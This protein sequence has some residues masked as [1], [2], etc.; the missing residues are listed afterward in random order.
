MLVERHDYTLKGWQSANTKKY[1]LIKK[2]ADADR[3]NI[4]LVHISETC[5]DLYIKNIEIINVLPVDGHFIDK[6]CSPGGEFAI[7]LS[8]ISFDGNEEVKE[9]KAALCHYV[10]KDEKDEDLLP[11]G[12][13]KV[14]PAIGPFFYLG[15]HDPDANETA[16]VILKSE[17][18]AK[19]LCLRFIQW[20]KNLESYFVSTDQEFIRF[21]EIGA[22]P[23]FFSYI[24]EEMDKIAANQKDGRLIVIYSGNS[25]KMQVKITPLRI[26]YM[27]REFADLGY[28]VVYFPAPENMTQDEV[29]PLLNVWQFPRSTLSLFL[30]KV[31]NA[32]KAAGFKHFF[33]CSGAYDN[34]G[35]S[36]HD[37]CSLFNWQSLLEVRDDMEGLN[38]VGY[39]KWFSPA[40]EL[41]AAKIFNKISVVSER[42][43]DRFELLSK[44]ASQI[45]IIGNG[46]DREFYDLTQ[47]M[48]NR[49]PVQK[50]Y[51]K[52]I[53]GYI[54]HLTPLWFDW[55]LI[56]AA[57]IA[58]PDFQFELIGNNAPCFEN[59]PENIVIPG[60]I[61]RKECL[62]YAER[63]KGA[64]IPFKPMRVT[65]SI[66]P[67]KLYEYLA[68]G[69]PVLSSLMGGVT[70]SPLPHIY[71]T[72]DEF[73]KCLEKIAVEQ[74]SVGDM[75]EVEKFLK[76]ICGK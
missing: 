60:P 23:S 48:R 19:R 33:I 44:G 52:I 65:R 42:L 54:G 5:P 56:F 38:N 64:I 31:C 4:K 41:Y 28:T 55:E 2:Q 63:W 71:A 58:F 40:I 17:E 24:F 22:S 36:A 20:R 61:E 67:L 43:K 50:K 10:F 15:I 35:I 37:F 45:E 46:L 68:F 70:S 12:T 27:V 53:F 13:S 49:R 25:P 21:R 11:M 3:A 30:E 29:R 8:I 72:A 75:G 76:K 26:N 34:F 66:D 51:E 7:D 16:P 32:P 6:E 1:I 59:L 47:E 57:A 9:D 62:P 39:A 74:I 73:N 69:L 14:S 18:R